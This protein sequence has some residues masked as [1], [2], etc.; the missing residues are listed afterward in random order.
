MYDIGREPPLD[1]PE[2]YYITADCG[3]ECYY[4]ETVYSWDEKHICEDCFMDKV[5]ELTASELAYLLNVDTFEVKTPREYRADYAERR[6][7]DYD[8]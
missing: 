7:P 2:E 8:F 1:P 5:Q 3:H 4:G 6:E